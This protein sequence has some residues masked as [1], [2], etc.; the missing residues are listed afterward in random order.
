MS[1]SLTPAQIEGLKQQAAYYAVDRFVQSGMV[2]GLGTG[3]TAEY[4]VREIARRLK[5]RRLR[6]V[7]GIPTSRRTAQLALD[8]GIPLGDLNSHPHVD[9]VLDGADEVDPQ[10]NLIKGL[11]GALLWE[12]IVA[13]AA[14][15]VV[16]MVDM[17]KQVK[18]LGTRSPLPVEVEPFGWRIHVP[19]L[20]ERGGQVRIRGTE[21]GEPFVTDGGHY[22][23]D[24]TF[25]NGIEDPL[26]LAQL[27]NGRAGIVEHGLFLGMADVIVVSTLKG[28]EVQE[29]VGS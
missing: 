20:E 14:Q 7:V 29:P 11:G 26:R 3:S 16:I 13:T 24:V 5:E 12:K 8:L 27:L 9:V 1:E 18:R 28:V 17:R 19:F 21:E 4:A 2:V 6:H 22:I 23:L 15:K 10:G 25:P